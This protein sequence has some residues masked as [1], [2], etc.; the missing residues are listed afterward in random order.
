MEENLEIS[1]LLRD[2]LTQN[3]DT[4]LAAEELRQALNSIIGRHKLKPPAVISLL[5]RLS[6]GY[7]HLT[8]KVYNQKCTDE[9]V[10]EDFHSFLVATL[11]SLDMDDVGFEIEKMK[12]EE[13]N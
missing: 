11:T 4:Q 7:I 2:F 13:L 10:E 5:A 8:Q 1:P 3:Q 9:V 6:A 12:K